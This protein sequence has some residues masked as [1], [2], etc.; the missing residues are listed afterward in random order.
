MG[1]MKQSTDDWRLGNSCLASA[2]SEKAIAAVGVYRTIYIWVGFASGDP[3]TL[4]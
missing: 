4:R 1:W 3:S 2:A